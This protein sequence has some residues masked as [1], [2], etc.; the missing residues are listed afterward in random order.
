MGEAI[1]AAMSW[2]ISFLRRRRVQE[3]LKKHKIDEVLKWLALE[4]KAARA[5]INVAE[6]TE[7][8]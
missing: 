6:L 3:Y 7:V 4:I 8:L 5:R 2:V 1:D